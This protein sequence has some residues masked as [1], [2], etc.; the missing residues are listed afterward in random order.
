MSAPLLELIILLFFPPKRGRWLRT[1]INMNETPSQ[2]YCKKKWY[3]HWLRT[4]YFNWLRYVL[5]ILIKSWVKKREETAKKKRT[6]NWGGSSKASHY[7]N[8]A[9]ECVSHGI[10]EIWTRAD[11]STAT[12]VRL[13]NHSDTIPRALGRA[14]HLLVFQRT[15]VKPAAATIFLFQ[16]AG[17]SRPLIHQSYVCKVGLCFVHFLHWF[18]HKQLW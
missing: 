12:W 8:A 18:E 3:V 7:L 2:G 15:S 9:H 4:P 5:H 11:L 14:D 13:L 10:D 16:S 1:H 17:L 6:L